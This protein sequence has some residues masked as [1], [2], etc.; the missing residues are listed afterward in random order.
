MIPK[1]PVMLLSFMNMRLRDYGMN[2]DELCD[3]LDV[4]RREIEAILAKID[5]NYDEQQKQFV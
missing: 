4:E 1:D 5:Y 2:L 3:D